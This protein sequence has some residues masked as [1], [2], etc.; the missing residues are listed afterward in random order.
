M[1]HEQSNQHLDASQRRDLCVIASG[2]ANIETS[3]GR[4]S[5]PRLDT[6]F[7]KRCLLIAT[8]LGLLFA[9]STLR[10]AAQDDPFDDSSADPIKLFERGQG[11]HARGDLE[12][13]LAFYE[14]AL[15]VKPE[16]PEAEFQ[17]G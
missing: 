13:A 16:F 12:K 14:Q 11:A 3:P 9:G 2:Y 17:R 5:M 7:L 8:C 10:A 15:K 4:S 6:L 1:H